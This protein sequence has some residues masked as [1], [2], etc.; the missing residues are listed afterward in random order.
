M[1]KSFYEFLNNLLKKEY[2]SKIA[3]EIIDGYNKKRATT[4]RVNTNKIEIEK[5][6]NVLKSS[7]ISFKNV[8]WC[9]EAFILENGKEKELQELGIYQDGQIYLQS[10]SSMIPAIVLNPQQKE[11]ILDMCAAPGG[12]TTQIASISQNQAYITACERNPIRAEKLK[13]NI[14]KQGCKGTIVMTKDA[15]ELDELLSFDKILLDAPCSGSGTINLEDEKISQ[16]FTKELISKSIKT[17]MT[18]LRKAI[19]LL[20]PGG[21]LVYS[22]C[23]ILKEENENIVQQ[24]ISENKTL[25]IMP[26]EM[27]SIPTLPCTLNGALIVKPNEEYEGFFIVKIKKEA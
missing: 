2:E 18:L 1:E 8:A 10:L 23:S 27:N 9:R 25:K 19:K 3:K 20:K 21:E 6:K 13:Y 16:Y 4:F 5:V 26:I 17:Q 22:T 7:N 11:N 14:Q 12:K 15:R 24:V